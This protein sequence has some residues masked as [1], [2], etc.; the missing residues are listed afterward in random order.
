M[1]ATPERASVVYEYILIVR[2]ADQPLALTVT[3]ANGRSFPSWE[4][5]EPHFWQ[6]VL[7]IN[8]WTRERLGVE[9]TVLGCIHL[10]YDPE[11]T[12][13]TRVYEL[14]CHTPD[15][16]LPNDAAWMPWEHLPELHGTR[17]RLRETLENWLA[18]SAC[19]G[20][21]RRA[22]A[23]PG[24]WDQASAW[25]RKALS[26][27]GRPCVSPLIQLRTWERSCVACTGDGE[28]YFKAVPSMFAHEPKLAHALARWHPEVSAEVVGT[29]VE[30][31]WFLM[32]S[33]GRQVLE[34]VPDAER[35]EE[36]ARTFARL[37]IALADR[38][39]GLLEL[40]CPDRRLDRLEGHLDALLADDEVLR[41]GLSPLSE[42]EIRQLRGL[43]PTL[44]SMC[45]RLAGCGIPA[46]LEH[47]DFWAGQVVTRD[48][49]HAFIDWSDSS[50]SC[51]FFSM[52]TFLAIQSDTLPEPRD[53]VP[54]RLRDAYLSEWSRHAPPEQLREALEVAQWLAP[55][56]N[57]VTY[58]RLILPFMEA[59]WEMENMVP[60][61][62]RA[63]LSGVHEAAA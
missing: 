8:V 12:R 55:L 3:G 14:E 23:R 43:G 49:G 52:A 10:E 19:P 13:D 45:G 22:W 27:R 36:A 21:P 7:P 16:T 4:T 24:W 37:Q 51:P 18:Q 6:V 33:A 28:F 5:T 44:K 61:Y 40:G 25:T 38:V 42:G 53:I 34:N 60:F 63:L 58:Q 57:A 56:H 17:P 2:H 1:S 54:D 15:C 47:G 20:T 30:Q 50:V 62:L 29:D 9:T 11:Q 26:G 48:E 35:W 32:K 41:C 39:E 31:G 46:S 59:R